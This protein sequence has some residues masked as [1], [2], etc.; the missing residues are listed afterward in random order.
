M[1]KS[2]LSHPFMTVA[3]G[4]LTFL[5]LGYTSIWTLVGGAP[6]HGSLGLS[7]SFHPFLLYLSDCLAHSVYWL[8]PVIC[9]TPSVLHYFSGLP[10]WKACDPAASW[11]PLV[12]MCGAAE[13]YRRIFH[14][15]PVRCHQNSLPSLLLVSYTPR[16]VFVISQ[17]ISL[18]IAKV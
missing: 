1:V 14:S 7:P 4:P 15:S 6:S 11:L 13:G 17:V 2:Q 16:N 9:S 12:H 5:S 10:A 8:G 18:F 3:S